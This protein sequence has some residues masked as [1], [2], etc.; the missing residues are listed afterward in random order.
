MTESFFL[1]FSFCRLPRRRSRWIRSPQLDIPTEDGKLICCD[2]LCMS[3][4]AL[5][6]RRD[7]LSHKQG[8]EIIHLET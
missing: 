2:A 7:A 1:L 5:C 6:D 4:A 3:W 8:S